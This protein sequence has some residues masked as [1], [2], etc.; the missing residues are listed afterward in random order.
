M[1]FDPTLATEAYAYLTTRGRRSGLPREIEIWFALSDDGATVHLMA[2]GGEGANWVRNLR[3]DPDV[4][5]RIGPTTL[6]GTAAALEPGPEDD[7]AREALVLK[8]RRGEG[9]LEGWRRGGL[10][11]A[12]R[13]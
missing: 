2:G 13:V 3:A 10:A 7:A 8:Y 12:I 4:S 1:P 6:A 11:V 5:V 9:D